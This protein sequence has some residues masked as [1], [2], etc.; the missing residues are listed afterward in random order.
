MRVR[1]ICP[2]CGLSGSVDAI[3]AGKI[4]RC[5]RCGRQAPVPKPG[6]QETD[7]YALAEPKAD[8]A[9]DWAEDRVP[10]AVSAMAPG[11]GATKAPRPRRTTRRSPRPRARQP[12]A[13]F[14]WRNW[15]I[16]SVAAVALTLVAVSVLAP[17]GTAI[18]GCVVILIGCGML[19]SGFLAGAYGAFHEDFLY[20]F[21]YVVVPL[22]TAY[23][24]VT[25]WDDLWVWGACSTAG[26]GLILLGTEI[27]RWSGVL[28]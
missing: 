22:Y 18:A 1:F 6:E 4:I 9:S 21:L 23:Y 13:H 8:P 25:R 16:G 19:L 15:L 7:L 27:I 20:G 10:G 5:K 28:A 24:V 3:H 17:R 26:I 14:W 2:D 11:A 12:S